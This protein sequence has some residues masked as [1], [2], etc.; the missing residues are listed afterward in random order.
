MFASIAFFFAALVLGGGSR[1][2][3]AG[4]ILL[5]L[6]AIGALVWL[7]WN[8]AMRGV[9][10]PKFAYVFWAGLLLLPLIQLIPLPWWLWTRF[11][12]REVVVE[13]YQALGVT[14]MQPISLA[15]ERTVNAFFALIPVVT[16]FFLTLRL[17][18]AGREKSIAWII[19]ATV[20]SAVLGLLQVVS[21]PGSVLY[22]Y[23]ITNGDASVGLF[24]NANHHSLFL[25][26][27]IVLIFH[28]M[29]AKIRLNRQLPQT[30]LAMGGLALLCLLT[31][32]VAT[33]SRAGVLFAIVAVLVGL[34]FIPI[35]M[36]RISRMRFW[37]IAAG[38]FLF[39][40][41]VFSVMF[42]SR[43]FGT[44]DEG[45]ILQDGRIDNLWVFGRMIADFFPIGS[46]LGTFDPVYRLY[47]T[48]GEIDLTYLNNAHNDGA[49][50]LLEGGLWGGL[51]LI[52][53][54]GWYGAQTLSVL[55]VSSENMVRVTQRR[56][57]CA[58]IGLALAHS[59]VDYP[60]RT[61][62]FSVLFG[63][64]A[65]MLMYQPPSSGRQR[66]GSTKA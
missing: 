11:P 17:D 49:Q 44:A 61:G 43:I 13:M 6:I 45:G 51:L 27:G 9:G 10:L 55:R 4:P 26:A 23:A 58:I 42:F 57:M 64:C 48:A 5:R 52:M 37:G 21:G 34:T 39:A 29:S 46:G 63:M 3:L 54:L 59:L 12:G 8:G 20:I 28:W 40:T 14:P 18:N 41:A 24:S 7:L 15:P 16:A 30:E 2:E 22:I 66:A 53:F 32:V 31:S 36:L 38:V 60:L 33:L 65:A 47:E 35:N 1:L 19:T 62:A 50:I 56:A 25:C